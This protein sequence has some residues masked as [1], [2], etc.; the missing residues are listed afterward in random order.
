MAKII[1]FSQI[2]DLG[3][4]S[5][6]FDEGDIIVFDG[7]MLTNGDIVFNN[8]KIIGRG[9]LFSNIS[10]VSG[11][12]DEFALRAEW[13][14]IKALYQTYDN[15][16]H[17][18]FALK[19]CYGT[20]VR[21][22]IFNR[23][24]Y[25]VDDRVIIGN[26]DN[27]NNNANNGNNGNNENPSNYW[28]INIIGAGKNIENGTTFLLGTNGE[29]RIPHSSTPNPLCGGSIQHCSFFS[30]NALNNNNNNRRGGKGIYI[31]HAH[32]YNIFDCGFYHLNDA[33]T[34]YDHTYYTHIKSCGFDDCTNAI[35]T[36]VEETIN[37]V[38]VQYEGDA[39]DNMVSNC[40]FQYCDNPIFLNDKSKGWHIYDCDIEGENGTC[41]LGNENRMT[42][43]RI[44]RNQENVPWLL[45]K[46]GCTVSADI[47]GL[48]QTTHNWKCV[49]EGDNNHADLHFNT[50]T[51]LGF[52]ALGRGNYFNVLCKQAVDPTIGNDGY[53]PTMMIY[54]PEDTVIVNGFSNKEDYEGSGYTSARMI[55]RR[56]RRREHGLRQFHIHGPEF[57]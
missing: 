20:G 23:G 26:P 57:P 37:N 11:S 5:R 17:I 33:I 29:F 18:N 52:I 48:G 36:I 10:S 8:N 4:N 19:F 27:L 3:G 50:Y 46:N 7:G 1:I 31:G 44:E 16:P 32:C 43:V 15:T 45:C 21:N 53:G 54:D 34:L 51:P 30:T 40:M 14:G 38:I 41:C 22:L 55:T 39:N 56:L 9:Q 25:F 13:F 35:K 47:H 2:E 28:N 24:N 6:T 42:N 12:L 49:F